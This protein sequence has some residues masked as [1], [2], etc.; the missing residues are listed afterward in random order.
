MTVVDVSGVVL[1]A[2]YGL[3]S[4]AYVFFGPPTEAVTRV[5]NAHPPVDLRWSEKLP[6]LI[7]LVALLVVGFWPK[8]LSTPL[9]STL[10]A[11]F[12]GLDAPRLAAG[13]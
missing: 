11:A 12:S 10:N 4:V 7:L 1:S 6:A 2:I 9:N 8:S 13:K 5:T 3:R